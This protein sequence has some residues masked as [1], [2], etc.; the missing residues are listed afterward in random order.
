MAS[1]CKECATVLTDTNARMVWSGTKNRKKICYTRCKPCESKNVVRV[2]HKNHGPRANSILHAKT[3]Y[4][5]SIEEYDNLVANPCSICGSN[6]SVV[7]DH[8]HNTNKIRG[9]LCKRCNQGLGL[10][11]D[12]V[13]SLLNA[14]RYLQCNSTT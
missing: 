10:F 5:L 11:K 3:R 12:N 8:D 14:V 9:P 1:H 4:G 13:Q 6:D 7:I 2:R